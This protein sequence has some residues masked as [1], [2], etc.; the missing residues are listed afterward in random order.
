LAKLRKGSLKI[1]VA[2][3]LTPNGDQITDNGLEPD[4][5]VELTEED[6]E[7]DKDPQLDRA[8]EILKEIK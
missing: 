8:I 3:W 4:V 5:K 1:T 2:S 7:Q 6:F